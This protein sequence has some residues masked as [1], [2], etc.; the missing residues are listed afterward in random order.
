M[1]ISVVNANEYSKLRFRDVLHL[2]LRPRTRS[3]LGSERTIMFVFL[4]GL[5]KL[6]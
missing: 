1:H 6:G 5:N 2:L 4:F 3:D